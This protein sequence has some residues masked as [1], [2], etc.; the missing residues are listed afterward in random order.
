[1]TSLKLMIA[2]HKKCEVPSDPVYLPLQVG[3]AG[4]DEIGF[5]R[6]DTGENISRLNPCYCELTGLYWC[7]KNLDVDWL[8]LVHYRRY[9][10]M[11]SGTWRRQ[12]S[13]LEGALTQEEAE[14][15]I[16]TAK[17]IVPKKRRYYIESIYSHYSHTFDHTRLDTC[18][19]I[20]VSKNPSYVSAFDSVMKSTGGY[21]FNMF[22]MDHAMVDSYCSWLF[23]VLQQLIDQTDSSGMSDFEKRY[24]GRISEILF[25]VWLKYQLETGTVKPS[26]IREVSYYYL[27]KIDW[28]RKVKSF[29]AA[30]FLHKKYDRSF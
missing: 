25:N 1:M 29:L 19:N 27:G 8:G 30:K 9:F 17:I 10:T 4:K 26:E 21:M 3:A 16:K 24:A 7:W 18:R 23:D 20:L 22:L 14:S 13:E 28:G 12:H 15:L 6:D 5:T 11:K 2:C